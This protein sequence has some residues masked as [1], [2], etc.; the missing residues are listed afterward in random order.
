MA[1]LLYLRN[2]ES[3]VDVFCN[4]QAFEPLY[5][6]VQNMAVASL[7]IDYRFNAVNED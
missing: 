7:K 1:L 4:Y 5:K 6:V 3:Y 2:M